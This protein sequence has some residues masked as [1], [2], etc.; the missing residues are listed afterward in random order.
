MITAILDSNV[1]VQSLIGAFEAASFQTVL[2]CFDREFRLIVGQDALDELLN[3]LSIPK[4]RERHGL[5]PPQILVF[6]KALL[7][8]AETVRVDFSVSPTLTR[9]VTDAKFL[10]LAE[11]SEADYLVTND[12]RHLLP[13]KRHGH[14]Q[15][16]VPGQFLKLIRS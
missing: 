13:L 3:V 2:A 12:R 15:I 7:A 8:N 1:V 10:A 9:D 4:I 6:V 5:S 11:A 14:T 16:V